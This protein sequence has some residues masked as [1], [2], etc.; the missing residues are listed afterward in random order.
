MARQEDSAFNQ[1]TLVNYYKILGLENYATL[2]EVRKAY[3]GLV[4]T[5][6]P[7]VVA[8]ELR[9]EATEIFKTVLLA[10]TVLNHPGKKQYYDEQLQS[11]IDAVKQRVNTHQAKT[12]KDNAKEAKKDAHKQTSHSKSAN[13]EKGE[14][15]ASHKHKHSHK[16]NTHKNNPIK[17]PETSEPF[18]AVPSKPMFWKKWHTLYVVESKPNTW[19]ATWEPNAKQRQQAAQKGIL[20]KCVN[21]YTGTVLQHVQVP[22]GVIPDNSKACV[23]KLAINNSILLNLQVEKVNASGGGW[24]GVGESQKPSRPP[25]VQSSFE[26]DYD[27]DDDDAYNSDEAFVENEIEDDY[28]DESESKS[29]A[30]RSSKDVSQAGSSTK[31]VSAQSPGASSA[32]ASTSKSSQG[33]SP[34][35]HTPY[36]SSSSASVNKTVAPQA[37]EIPLMLEVWEAVLGTEKKVQLPGSGTE[38][39]ELGSVTVPAGIQPNKQLRITHNEKSYLF[40][41]SI[42]IPTDLSEEARNCYE[43]LQ[44]LSSTE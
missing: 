26:D 25:K 10:Y 19:H 40:R 44:H 1:G 24:F 5:T 33:S 8:P 2:S 15:G 38:A 17:P 13:G 14:K 39:E 21:Y 41:V 3:R 32:H 6:H 20:F 31:Q 16:H 11:V 22:F 34:K 35:P 42:V 23:L 18:I 7:D 37:T 12:Q 27:D 4:K 28:E 36:K 9:G 43:I 30:V 29:S